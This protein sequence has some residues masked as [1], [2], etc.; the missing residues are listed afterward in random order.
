MSTTSYTIPPMHQSRSE[1]VTRT[2]MMG[3]PRRGTEYY[4]DDDRLGDYYDDDREGNL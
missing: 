2:F 4:D 1:G 3:F